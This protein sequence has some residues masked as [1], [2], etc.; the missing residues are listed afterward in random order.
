MKV[1]QGFFLR[2][3]AT[4]L[5]CRAPLVAQ[6][7]RVHLPVQVTWGLSLVQEDPCAEQ[8]S[9]RTAAGEAHTL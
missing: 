8:L 1:R 7:L 6:W 2:E 4:L 5:G 3:N 9:P